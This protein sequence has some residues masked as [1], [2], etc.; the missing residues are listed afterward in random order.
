MRR[1]LKACRRLGRRRP[2]ALI[3][4]RT[5]MS[6]WCPQFVGRPC[7]RA[8]PSAPFGGESDRKKLRGGISEKIFGVAA[9][10]LIPSGSADLNGFAPAVIEAASRYMKTLSAGV[11]EFGFRPVRAI[12]RGLH[13]PQQISITITLP[14]VLGEWPW[15]IADLGEVRRAKLGRAGFQAYGSERN[16][17]FHGMHASKRLNTVRRNS[18]D[19]IVPQWAQEFMRRNDGEDSSDAGRL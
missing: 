15:H 3:R 14:R 2:R 13:L 16:G 5:P 4:M 17:A 7:L 11:F 12:G 1:P 9:A 8:H 18:L 10:G 19:V 6:R